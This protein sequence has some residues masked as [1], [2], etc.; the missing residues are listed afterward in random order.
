MSTVQSHH[1]IQTNEVFDALQRPLA[2]ID[3]PQR[4]EDMQRFIDTA[5]V[6]QERAVFDLISDLVAKVN[7]ASGDTKVRLEYQARE[8]RL[9]VDANQP[10]EDTSDPL[11]RMDGDL[12]KVT[13][14]LPRPLKD[15]IDKV[16][17]D[18][19][20]SLNSWYV[21]TLARGVAHQTRGMRGEV[22][23]ADPF[24]GRA[25]RRGRGRFGGRRSEGDRD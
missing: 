12:D 7:E 9:T 11:T 3:E 22:A 20:V 19:G 1:T 5:R 6:H 25:G 18:R 2:L 23:G 14:R 17:A 24:E 10:A 13:I 8:F 4:R 21:R 15:L 16:A